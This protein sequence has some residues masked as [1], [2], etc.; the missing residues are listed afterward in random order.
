MQPP[1]YHLLSDLCL[2]GSQ[3]SCKREGRKGGARE[4]AAAEIE[5]ILGET[6]WQETFLENNIWSKRWENPG[7]SFLSRG[8]FWVTGN[9]KPPEVI[10]IKK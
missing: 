7:G 9:R 8:P 1:S 2:R 5:K 6:K 10:N 4:G 3:P